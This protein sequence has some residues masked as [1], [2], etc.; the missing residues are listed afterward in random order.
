MHGVYLLHRREVD[1][2]EIVHVAPKEDPI[3]SLPA[4]DDGGQHEAINA[5][6]PEERTI[7]PLAERSE[8]PVDIE[9]Y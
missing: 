7:D 1:A 9:D 3:E 6:P 4:V 8:T 5:A 2:A